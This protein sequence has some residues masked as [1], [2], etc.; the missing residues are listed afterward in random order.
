[1]EYL[2]ELQ[3]EIETVRA[4]LNVAAQE[5]ISSQKCYQTSKRLSRLIA[6]YM[7]YTKEEVQLQNCG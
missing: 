6:D 4:Q 2:Q 1:M 5:D 7:K 3:T